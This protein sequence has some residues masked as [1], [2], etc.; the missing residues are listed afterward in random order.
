MSPLDRV[1]AA[2]EEPFTDEV[3]LGGSPLTETVTVGVAWFSDVIDIDR[4][5]VPP[6]S[7]GGR[8]VG[9]A[10][11]MNEPDVEMTWNSDM[12]KRS[13]GL[14]RNST[15]YLP[16]WVREASVGTVMTAVNVPSVATET[17]VVKVFSTGPNL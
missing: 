11:S 5:A 15:G 13:V 2:V 4:V 3:I 9:D 12:E 14:E 10:A 7:T 16:P 8:N 6:C 17:G 1:T